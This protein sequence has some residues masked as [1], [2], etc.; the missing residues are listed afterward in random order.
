MLNPPTAYEDDGDA[1]VDNPAALGIH[2]IISKG[3]QLLSRGRK[4]T[5]AGRTER[6][7]PGSG[8]GTDEKGIPDL[9]PP[10]GAQLATPNTAIRGAR[11][12]M[13]IHVCHPHDPS[14]PTG[15]FIFSCRANKWH[16]YSL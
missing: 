14:D 16:Y 9:E 1:G 12:E 13:K 4:Q 7:K 11:D 3:A 5:K 8:Q 10:T 6:T 2:I 15:V